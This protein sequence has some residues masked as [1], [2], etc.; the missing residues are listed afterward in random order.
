MTHPSR[1]PAEPGRRSPL[2]RVLGGVGVVGMASPLIWVV[3]LAV[4]WFVA[5][6]RL[7][8]GL[9]FTVFG[10]TL[11]AMIVGVLLFAWADRLDQRRLHPD[12]GAP[13]DN[14]D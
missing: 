2:V 9:V 10:S 3:V 6:D 12:R 13:A 1:T 14:N 5:R 4:L 8:G 7:N 11:L